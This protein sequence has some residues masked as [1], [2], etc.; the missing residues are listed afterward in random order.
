MTSKSAFLS[1]KI[2]F[3]AFLMGSLALSQ[4][5]AAVDLSS[6]N[7]T[8]QDGIVAS[9]YEPTGVYTLRKT[10]FTLGGLQ[11][12]QKESRQNASELAALKETVKAQTRLIEELK[13]NNG[14]TT[15][16]SNADVSGLKSKMDEQSRTISKLESQLNDLKR[17]AGSSSSSNSSSSDLSSLK[18]KVE[19]QNRSISKL[20]SKLSDIQRSSGSSSN[21]S[22]SDISSLRQDISNLRSSVGRLE[23]Q[24]SSLSSKVK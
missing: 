19:D 10:E 21:S 15:Q 3:A 14:T 11:Q 16:T 5:Q 6:Y 23:S 7:A 17:S 2:R 8:S 9:H 18:S 22:S 1:S 24:V 12:L 20:E 13:R 4:A